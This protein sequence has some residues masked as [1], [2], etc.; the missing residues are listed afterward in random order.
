MQRVKSPLLQNISYFSRSLLCPLARKKTS[1]TRISNSAQPRVVGG[2]AECSPWVIGSDCKWDHPAFT[3]WLPDPYI[4]PVRNIVPYRDLWFSAYAIY[5][6][7]M[8]HH[9]RVL[10]LNSW[11]SW[12]TLVPFPVLYDGSF[13]VHGCSSTVYDVTIGSHRYGAT[14]IL[15]S[16]WIW[17]FY[18]CCAI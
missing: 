16:L 13:I 10:S 7:I 5:G 12:Y 18:E 17:Y 9:C 4:F 3:T 11:F 8:H 1:R 14:S 15:H 6:G 2:E